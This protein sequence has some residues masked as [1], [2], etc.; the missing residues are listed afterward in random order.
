MSEH[1]KLTDK[2]EQ[3]CLEYLID[4]NATQSA[5]RA[6]YSKKTAYSIG[7]ENLKKPEIQNRISELKEE[8]SKKVSLTA[9]DVLKEL[10]NFAYSDI[11]E[12]ILL[13]TDQIKELSPDIR[14]LITSYKKIS[15]KYGENDEFEE[16]SVELRFVDKMKAFEMLN[17]HIGFYEV[18]NKQQNPAKN[19]FDNYSE[20][21]LKTI[22]DIE[23][24][25]KK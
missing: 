18:D 3:F 8:R 14:R 15:K 1:K 12:T 25:Y 10:K 9:L 4:L 17:K 16:E 20:E 5:I 11:T 19:N 13:T 2:Q 23:K 7:Q 24:K 22:I 6:G 21:D